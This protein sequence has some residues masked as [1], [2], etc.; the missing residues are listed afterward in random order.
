MLNSS[1]SLAMSTRVLKALPGK[2][3]IKVH[4]PC[5]LYVLHCNTEPKSVHLSR[6]VWCD[7]A[8]G[9]LELKVNLRL[10]CSSNLSY[11]VNK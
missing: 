1:A 8:A 3:D 10:A 7:T 11:L 9:L 2:F 4:S 6:T 5:I